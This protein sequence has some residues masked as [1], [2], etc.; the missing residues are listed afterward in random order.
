MNS[1]ILTVCLAGVVLLATAWLLLSTSRKEGDTP[2]QDLRPAPK[3]SQSRPSDTQPSSTEP[4]PPAMAPA[5]A[6]DT[7]DPAVAEWVAQRSA[8]VEVN[9]TQQGK[10]YYPGRLTVKGVTVDL[11][12]TP[13]LIH[14]QLEARNCA[15]LLGELDTR[16]AYQRHLCTVRLVAGKPVMNYGV[17]VSYSR[18]ATPGGIAFRRSESAI[19]TVGII[20]PEI[21]VPPGDDPSAPQWAVTVR[22][23]ERTL[24]SDELEK[25]QPQ[26]LD[27]N[28]LVLMQTH[29]E[30]M[31]SSARILWLEFDDNGSLVVANR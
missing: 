21:K 12:E 29:P 16:H 26:A 17:S 1:R 28:T 13:P 2:P 14:H 31:T 18:L 8:G 4:S 20:I 9:Q 24:G 22:V 6:A 15:L 27:S 11:G 19:Q 30:G 7:G 10:L 25:I 3:V 5:S 23:A